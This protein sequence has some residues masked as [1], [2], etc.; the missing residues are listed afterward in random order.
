MAAYPACESFGT[1]FAIAD[2]HK[3]KKAGRVVGAEPAAIERQEEFRGNQ[4][5]GEIGVMKQ[6]VVGQRIAIAGGQAGQVG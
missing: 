3:T 4:C 1:Q 2:D 5:G 6:L